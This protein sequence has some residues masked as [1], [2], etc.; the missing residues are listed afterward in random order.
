VPS[1][2]QR[3]LTR[4]LPSPVAGA[5]LDRVAGQVVDQLT[6]ADRVGQ[7]LGRAARVDKGMQADLAVQCHRAQPIADTFDQGLELDRL[8]FELEPAGLDLG[9]VEDVV[10]QPQQRGG[11]FAH[12]VHGLRLLFVEV[13]VGQQ[14]GHAQHT[15]HGRADLVT[16]RRQE[17]GLGAVGG[18]GGIAGLRAWPARR[19]SGR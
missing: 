10:D 13:A 8:V 3:T 7:H 4:P 12:R 1:G 11:R 5:E 14:L 16:H 9:E 19:P 17:G 2:R 15:V 18:L 6:Q